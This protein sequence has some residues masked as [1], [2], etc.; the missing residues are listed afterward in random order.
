MHSRNTP[1]KNSTKIQTRWKYGNSITLPHALAASP[2]DHPIVA[3]AAPAAA[4]PLLETTRRPLLLLK[5]IPDIPMAK[6]SNCEPVSFLS[7]LDHE[8]NCTTRSSAFPTQLSSVAGN[9][10]SYEDQGELV[11]PLLSREMDWEDELDRRIAIHQKWSSCED[12]INIK[13]GNSSASSRVFF[14]PTDVAAVSETLCHIRK[15]SSKF[16][17]H[18][19][20]YIALPFDEDIILQLLCFMFKSWEDSFLKKP[21][22]GAPFIPN[23]C[24]VLL[25]M[26]AAMYLNLQ[27]LVNICSDLAA[28]YITCVL[29]LDSLAPPL[30]MDILKRLSIYDLRQIEP[31]IPISVSPGEV[32]RLWEQQF[33]RL[34]QKSESSVF[35]TRAMLLSAESEHDG[36]QYRTRARNICITKL[37]EEQL[38]NT[39]SQ[40][41]YDGLIA[42]GKIDGMILHNLQV[43]FGIC[44]AHDPTNWTSVLALLVNLRSIEV[45][46]KGP[47]SQSECTVFDSFFKRRNLAVEINF[48]VVTPIDDNSVT[49]LLNP[50][51]ACTSYSQTQPSMNSPS[52][53]RHKQLPAIHMSPNPKPDLVVEE[54]AQEVRMAFK[55]TSNKSGIPIQ[56]VVRYLKMLPSMVSITNLC[57][58]NHPLR[59][60]GAKIIASH[61]ESGLS[62][63]TTLNLS[64]TQLSAKGVMYIVQA[65]T[66]TTSS[67]AIKHI[68]LSHNT[69]RHDEYISEAARSTAKLITTTKTLE[70]LNLSGNFFGPSGNI[71]ICESISKNSTLQVLH[72]SQIDLGIG[73]TDLCKAIAKADGMSRLK[74]VYAQDISVLPRV[75]CE[76]LA[77]LANCKRTSKSPI[78]LERLALGGNALP[79][80]VGVLIHRLVSNPNLTSLVYLDLSGGCGGSDM[81]SS[82][83]LEDAESETLLQGLLGNRTLKHLDLSMQRL[84]NSVCTVLAKT[85]PACNLQDVILR[86]N[87]ITDEGVQVLVDCVKHKLM[88]G[89]RVTFDL[90]E[91]YV[92]DE[93]CKQM[94]RFEYGVQV[95]HVFKQ[96][97]WE[98]SF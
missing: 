25:V 19:R 52:I 94:K 57:L 65:C 3:L 91:N 75:F 15:C 21:I 23:L 71:A 76:G 28:K 44:K 8:L 81:Q 38:S 85:V 82:G 32:S 95:I 17:E 66:P 14:V 77:L 55:R 60:E 56:L 74:T 42:I 51:K 88:I 24:D 20:N 34:Q 72:V 33:C 36:Q 12:T 50:G 79:M 9:I 92:S 89:R 67:T 59:S 68:S 35:Q 61:L 29:S 48:H 63:I 53:Y 46:I 4:E 30:V 13:S 26:D 22:A 86:Q 40:Q 87:L 10:T 11:D 39:L 96:R 2:H 84:T 90:E 70:S 47:L 83:F 69:K 27:E 97:K 58:E 93:M 62:T 5:R 41:Q 43:E 80:D 18:S 54:H 1:A 6:V 98:H 64:S 7:R 16:L 73:F 31:D 45:S 49:S 78:A 37:F